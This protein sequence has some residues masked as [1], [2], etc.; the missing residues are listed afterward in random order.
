MGLQRLVPLA[1]ATLLVACAS[2]PTP[3]QRRE[4]STAL[5]AAHHWQALELNAGAFRLQAY[6]PRTYAPNPVLTVYV[7]GDGLAW[8]N[9]RQPSPDPTPLD[10]LALRLALA[11][12]TGN[13]AYLG[14][15]C[16]YLGTLPPCHARYWTDARFSEEVVQSLDQAVEQLKAR[17]GA[18]RLIIIGYSGGGALA[19][20]LAA[21]RSDV[22]RVVTVAGNLD[23]AA[24]TRY[25][26]VAPLRG[27][28]NPVALRPL[29]APVPQLHL[30]GEADTVMPADL[31]QAFI[32][33]YP[34][35]SRTRLRLIPGY[36]HHCCWARNWA[37][38]WREQVAP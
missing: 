15:P 7:E 11:Q 1:I 23:H 19:L 13:V 18:Q 34:A 26:R 20:L 30:V 24:W 16:Q 9:S 31:A 10:P 4:H 35:G 33:G 6:V 36:D 2:L 12:P 25:H 32:A 29:L 3:E 37:Q 38:L 5:A 8:L 21:R 17:A 14:R 27:S 28:L 22:E